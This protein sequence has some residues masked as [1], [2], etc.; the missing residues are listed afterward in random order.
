MTDRRTTSLRALQQSLMTGELSASQRLGA[1]LADDATCTFGA[2]T[3]DGRGAVLARLSGDW[4]GTFALRHLVWDE[5]TTSG[6]R[7]QVA[8]TVHGQAAWAPRGARLDLAFDADD[9]ITDVTVE[10]VNQP[11]GAPESTIPAIA[12]GVINNARITNHPMCIAYVTPDGKPAQTFRGSIQVYSDT[13]LCAW[14]RFPQGGFATAIAAN[15]N[16]SVIYQDSPGSHLFITGA[17]RIDSSDAVREAVF[18]LVPEVEQLHDPAMKGTALI[19]DIS[20]IRGWID[21]AWV[22]MQA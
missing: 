18:A 11:P 12:R 14:V 8:G 22:M 5:P 2:D 20:N 13:Q 7:I 6:D 4:A 19:I 17:A 16:V 15:P 21:D 3:F 1:V 9:R 10:I